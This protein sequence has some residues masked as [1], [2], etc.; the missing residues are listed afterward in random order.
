M[1][2]PKC[3]VVLGKFRPISATPST[4]VE[5]WYVL[6]EGKRYPADP[7]SLRAWADEG[8]LSLESQILRPGGEWQPLSAYPEL[9]TTISTGEIPEPY[10]PIDAVFAFEGHSTGGFLGFGAGDPN[11]AFVG[12]KRQLRKVCRSLGGDAVINCQFQ[13]RVAVGEGLLAKNQ[14]VEIFA[15]GTVVR[16]RQQKAD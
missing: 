7:E 13:Y 1:E 12:V 5:S 6:V 14:V 2:C 9:I 4:Q 8:R 16:T 3:G 11:Q 10:E 15:Y